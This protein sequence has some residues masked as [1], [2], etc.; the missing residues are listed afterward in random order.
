MT[1]QKR[2]W[3]TGATRVAAGALVVGVLLTGCAQSPG[4]AAVVDGRVI[5]EDALTTAVA[6]LDRLAPG[7]LDAS[8]V[9]VTMAATPYFLDAAAAN[10]VEP[11]EA[12]ARR[13]AAQL[14]EQ[15]G[16]S[17]DLGEGATEVLLFS[18]ANQNIGE[19]DNSAEVLEELYAELSAADVSTNPRRGT[20]DLSTGQLAPLDLPWVEQAA[21]ATA[22]Q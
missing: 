10:G 19:L 2:S 11:T 5:T 3:R 15:T 22:E 1:T 6:D 14:A 4:T 21:Q 17:A 8:T 20:L 18:V 13:L 16:G 9:L 7:Q 12:D